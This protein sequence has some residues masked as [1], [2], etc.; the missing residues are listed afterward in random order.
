[1][2]G[3]EKGIKEPMSTYLMMTRRFAPLFWTQFFAAFSDN[4][5]K[6]ALIFLI[7]FKVGGPTAN[8]LVM[9]APVIFIAPYFVLSAFGG[10]M[11]DRY[12]KALIAQRVK[13]AEIGVSALA[14]LGFWLHTVGYDTASVSVLFLSLFGFGVCGAL[15]GPIKYGI[16]PDHLDRSEL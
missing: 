14:V 7:L 12:D 10:E 9:L 5:L 3:P 13:F 2:M 15:F 1:M 8:V 4:F 6:Q 16:L 11:A